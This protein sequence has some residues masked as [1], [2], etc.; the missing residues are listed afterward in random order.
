MALTSLIILGKLLNISTSFLGLE[1]L[2]LLLNICEEQTKLPVKAL[3]KE[4]SN[5][6]YWNGST[7][8]SANQFPSETAYLAKFK[9]TM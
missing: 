5:T 1:F 4:P 2:V 9:T 3:C 6:D 8:N 7:R